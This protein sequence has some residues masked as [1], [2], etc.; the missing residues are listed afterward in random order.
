MCVCV[1]FGTALYLKTHDVQRPN[2]ATRPASSG[3]KGW[4]PRQGRPRVTLVPWIPYSQ[5]V[6][7]VDGALPS[8]P[9]HQ[10]DA[11]EEVRQ[12]GGLRSLFEQVKWRR[13]GGRAYRNSVI[14]ASRNRVKLQ[15][16]YS[17][18]RSMLRLCLLPARLV[19]PVPFFAPARPLTGRRCRSFHLGS[20]N[21]TV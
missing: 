9:V 21:T 5:L 8:S 14:E 10:S 2:T 20:V 4:T 15:F 6:P 13:P 16:V 19:F 7:L 1:F 17:G 11:G 18:E 3:A 12:A